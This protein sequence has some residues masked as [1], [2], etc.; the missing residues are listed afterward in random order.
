MEMNDTT[1]KTRLLV[2]DPVIVLLMVEGSALNEIL[3]KTKS[4]VAA[5]EDA[6][7]DLAIAMWLRCQQH[8]REAVSGRAEATRELGVISRSGLRLDPSHFD[9]VIEHLE[10]TAHALYPIGRYLAYVSVQ[11]AYECAK[12]ESRQP[13]KIMTEFLKKLD[14]QKAVL[15]RELNRRLENE[16]TKHLAAGGA[17]PTGNCSVMTA[18]KLGD[19]AYIVFDQP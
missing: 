1:R 7:P 2:T 8:V 5:I 3:K 11:M 16:V 10:P 14:E 19:P 9:E 13:T 15:T 12:S 18:E 4:T 17:T 6:N